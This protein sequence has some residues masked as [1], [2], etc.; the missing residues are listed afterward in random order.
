MGEAIFGSFNIC[1]LCNWE[2]DG[3]QLANPACGGGANRKS[4][5][6]YQQKSIQM[7][8][9]EILKHGS[10]KRDPTWRPL[11]KS[12]IKIAEIEK[13]EKYWKNN[14]ISNYSEVYWVKHVQ[15]K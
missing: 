1:P 14:G 2:D 11:N 7:L 8:P 4:L 3:V 9:P 13:E 15:L 12:E 10:Y 6:E 5:I